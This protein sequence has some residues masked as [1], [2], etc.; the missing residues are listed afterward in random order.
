M[1]LLLS[2]GNRHYN[3]NLTEYPKFLQNQISKQNFLVD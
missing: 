2:F 1:L 3:R